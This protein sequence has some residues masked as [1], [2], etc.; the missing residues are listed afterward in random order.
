MDFSWFVW[1]WLDCGFALVGCFGRVGLGVLDWWVLW[2]L[3]LVVCCDFG[4]CSW[5]TGLFCVVRLRLGF[6]VLSLRWGIWAGCFDIWGLGILVG[7]LC[8]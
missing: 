3:G 7:C 5:R 6:F 8:C 4:F 2:V 1:V